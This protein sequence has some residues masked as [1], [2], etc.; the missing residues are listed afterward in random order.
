MIE[1]SPYA[2]AFHEDPY[3]IYQRL[4]DEAP[5]YRSPDGDFYAL[6]HHA[7]VMAAFKDVQRFSNDHGVSIDPGARGE[8]AR[9]GTSFLATVA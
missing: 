6:S 2:Y 9:L 3:P 7:D 8:V 4:R 5:V 1:F